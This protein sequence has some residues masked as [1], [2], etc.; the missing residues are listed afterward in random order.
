MLIGSSRHMLKCL[1]T[2]FMSLCS[3]CYVAIMSG[4]SHYKHNNITL[5]LTK[6]HVVFVVMSLVWTRLFQRRTNTHWVR[7]ILDTV[8]IQ[9]F[10]QHNKNPQMKLKISFHFWRRL[11]GGK[12][13]NYQKRQT[14][15]NAKNIRYGFHNFLE[16]LESKCTCT[17]YAMAL[18]SI[19]VVTCARI[20]TVDSF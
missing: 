9:T 15:T 3:C 14:T 16:Q 17:K 5:V 12:N 2:T 8:R 13:Q 10:K 6:S 18:I 20:P 1:N 4:C 11:Q 7:L 19:K